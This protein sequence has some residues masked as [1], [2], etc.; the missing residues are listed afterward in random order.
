MHRRTNDRSCCFLVAGIGTGKY[1]IQPEN[2][3]CHMVDFDMFQVSQAQGLV[4][5]RKLACALPRR[6]CCASQHSNDL[7]AGEAESFVSSPDRRGVHSPC[8][9]YHDRTP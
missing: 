5:Y 7:A 1:R 9:K 4:F 6:I 8:S 3:L 2:I